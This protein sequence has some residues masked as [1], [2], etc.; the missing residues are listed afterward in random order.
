MVQVKDEKKNSPVVAPANR[1]AGKA[2]LI[3]GGT[4]GIGLAVAKAYVRE[5]AKVVIAARDSD[6]LKTA[7]GILKDLGGDVTAAKVD[8]KNRAAAEGL[9]TAAIRSYG[10][11]DILVNNAAILGPQ[12][13]ILR[14]PADDW[15]EVMR[16]N[17]DSVFWLTKAALSSMIS[18]N[19]GSI[20]NV[21]S[22]V[23]V[24]GRATWGAYA[25]SKAA[26]LN[27]TE[28]VAEE[29][30]RYQI[31][32]NAINPGPTRT[33]MRAEAAPKEDPETLPAPEDIV[34]PFIYLASDV[35]RGVTGQSLEARDWFGRTF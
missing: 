19:S 6:E 7:V 15:D 33:M 23:G 24:K 17:V 4:R 5:G 13:E 16:T 29:V 3:T 25:V 34:N 28:V 26:V 30:A 10:K 14:Y 9:Y 8:L 18:S 11:V 20:I 1:L 32:V 21:V 35:S 31:R 27:L 2:A 12:T 22:G